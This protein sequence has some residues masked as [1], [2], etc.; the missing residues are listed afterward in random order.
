MRFLLLIIMGLPVFTH[1]QSVD[2]CEIRVPSVVTM[3]CK[4]GND[5]VMQVSSNCKTTDYKI[6]V[7]NRWGNLLYTSEK[8]EEVWD[9]SDYPV[10][11]YYWLVKAR[12]ENG[13]N[14]DQEGY[15]QLL[16]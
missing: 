13:Q 12:C 7:Y 10:G 9:L 8:L 5:F 16:K 4:Y 15:F 14:I 6:N 1:A 11:T 2:S 3:D